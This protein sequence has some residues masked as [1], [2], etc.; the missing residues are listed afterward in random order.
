MLPN[1]S[2][3]FW[4]NMSIVLKWDWVD[5]SMFKGNEPFSDVPDKGS[6]TKQIQ[7]Y[8]RENLHPSCCIFRLNSWLNEMITSRQIWYVNGVDG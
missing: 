3:S 2:L 5:F 1:E 6:F 8:R 4:Q 7:T